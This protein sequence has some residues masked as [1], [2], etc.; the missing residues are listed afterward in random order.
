MKKR[1]DTPKYR[2]LLMIKHSLERLSPA[3]DLDNKAILVTM[4]ELK[5]K[6]GITRWGLEALL[7]ELKSEKFINSYCFVRQ[8]K[9]GRFY[10][11]KESTL[12]RLFDGK[13]YVNGSFYENLKK[14]VNKLRIRNKSES[15]E[16]IRTAEGTR[17]SDVKIKCLDRFNVEIVIMGKT[18]K[19]DYIDL[20]FADRRKPTDKEAKYIYAWSVLHTMALRAG[21][22]DLKQ[23]QEKEKARFIK[24]KQK[25][26][27]ILCQLFPD[28]QGDPFEDMDTLHNDTV[29]RLKIKVES[30]F[31][32]D[33]IQDMRKGIRQERPKEFLPSV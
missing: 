28:I 32:K 15:I 11:G 13:I 33:D 29:Y 25:L 6:Y 9:D 31:S 12:L 20:G 30:F 5:N 24:G 21:V 22:F 23:L 8:G 26:K 10:C 4:L 16:P 3:E 19:F 1:S 27:N 14:F 7:D 18:Y 17:W 2:L